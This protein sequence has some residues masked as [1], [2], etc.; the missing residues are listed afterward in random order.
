MSDQYDS[1]LTLTG[2]PDARFLP[3]PVRA[4]LKDRDDAYSA[5][6]D[7]EDKYLHL[8]A[9]DWR[10]QATA[11][12]RAA[13]RQAVADGG[14]PFELSSA[15]GKAEQDRPR[16]I[17]IVEDLAAK[18]RAADSKL[19][20]AVR[21]EMPTIA[22]A[23]GQELAKAKDA[24]LAAQRKADEARQTYGAVLAARSTAVNWEL[25]VFS[26]FTGATQASPRDAAGMEP[27]DVYQVPHRPGM[28]EVQAI[29]ASFE[30]IGVRDLY[31]ETGEPVHQ[32]DPMV[33]VRAHNSGG[34]MD[35]KRS[36]ALYLERQGMV[37]V[38][39]ADAA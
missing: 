22:R 12:D 16:A 11:A 39:D 34:V 35:M 26:D 5:W 1:Y 20:D 36:H 25:G 18:V 7:A 31:G 32:D 37:T 4:L 14:D 3:R 10:E 15:L 8:L 30:A 19:R 27:R 17:A 23:I 33:R 29:E 28:P 13:A 21:R 9:P 38:L 2:V 24:Y 6:V